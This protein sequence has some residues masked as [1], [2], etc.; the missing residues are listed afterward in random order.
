MKKYNKF[1]F[2]FVITALIAT[3]CQEDLIDAGKY[4]TKLD[5]SKAPSATTSNPVKV[6]AAYAILAGS[7]IGGTEDR[8]ILLSASDDFASVTV[9][10]ASSEGNFEV[11]AESLT[12]NKTYYY[13]SYATNL[14]GG[15]SLGEIKSFKTRD[16]F[17]AFT[18][19]YLTSPM[20]D[21]LDAGFGDIDKDGDGN[22][23]YMVYYDEE[24]SQIWMKS[25]SWASSPLTPENY[26]LLPMMNFEGVDGTLT[27]N[28]QS[29]DANYPAEKFKV[30]V[31]NEPITVDNCQQAEVLFTHTMADGNVFTK[32]IE[33]PA[34]YEGGEVYFAIAHFDCTDNYQLAFLGATFSYAK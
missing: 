1:F 30:V 4:D 2:G 19:D 8:G 7:E 31:S 25:A 13:R 28:M 3:S 12:P 17:T 11:K 21:W 6:S 14:E 22:S 15:T 23:W 9:I 27:I 29:T 32:A 20:A 5:A 16:G 18:I 26:L 10:P 34:S 24:A 33:V